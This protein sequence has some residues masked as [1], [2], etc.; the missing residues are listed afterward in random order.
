MPPAGRP[1]T[2]NR[3]EALKK[4]MYIFWEKGYEGT[5]MTDLIVSNYFLRYMILQALL[6]Q[7]L[8]LMHCNGL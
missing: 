8:I 3:D 7:L 2:F 6:F 1:R 5:S 4:A